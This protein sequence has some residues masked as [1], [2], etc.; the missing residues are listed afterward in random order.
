MAKNQEYSNKK[1]LK[2]FIKLL[3]EYKWESFFWL[4]IRLIEESFMLVNIFL[5]GIIVNFFVNYEKDGNLTIFYVLLG[6]I[7][8]ISILGTL[9]R[10]FSKHK[11]GIIS[12]AVRKNVRLKAFAKILEM[13]LLWHDKENTGNKLQ[14][15]NEGARAA[16]DLIKFMY[17]SGIAIIVNIIGV[18]SVFL[19]ISW[20]YFIL[21]FVYMVVYLIVES[22]VNKKLA[23]QSKKVKKSQEVLIGKMYEFSSNITTAKS[24]GLDHS[25]KSK[26]EE[27]EN[28]LMDMYK[29][30]RKRIITKW[31]SIQLVS[32][33]FFA[34]FILTV[35]LDIAWGVLSVGIFL[36]YV[37]YYRKLHQAMNLVSEYAD[38][39]IDKKISI[40]RMLP[41]FE[42]KPLIVDAPGAKSITKWG[43]IVIKDVHFKYKRKEVLNGVNLVI[44]KGDKIGIKGKSGEGKSTLFKLLMKLYLPEKGKI[45]FDNIDY[46]K[47]KG[48]SIIDKIA[49]VPQETEL[50]NLSFAENIFIAGK[51]QDKKR[52]NEAIRIAQLEQVVKRLPNGLNSLIGEKGIRLSGGERQRLG[53]ARALYKDSPILLLDEATSHLD[54]KTE[55]KLLDELNKLNCTMIFIA[56]RESS[57]KG[58][59]TYEMKKGV[60][61]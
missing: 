32:N 60:F 31:T 8:S 42:E 28:I 44:K 27:S 16:T 1:F 50:F 14:R 47:I 22:K 25:L 38:E 17:K 45:M 55:K 54:T 39:L 15:I 13:D 5:L 43:K 12:W 11:L 26:T 56:H 61:K 58:M 49:F 46:E 59:K 53:I 2:D 33:I 9:M 21:A 48:K 37:E 57:L 7:L 51:K 3:G 6:I 24:L 52:L 41:I 30:F 18:C 23:E 36:V 35:G 20:K 40:Y 10:M 29:Q 34:V 4:F 19:V